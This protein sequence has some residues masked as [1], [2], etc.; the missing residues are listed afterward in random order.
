MTEIISVREKTTSDISMVLLSNEDVIDLKDVDHVELEMIDKSRKAYHYS[1]NDSPAYLDIADDPT[2]GVVTFTP[3]GE[4]V[5]LYQR[6]P[7]RLY[8][9]VYET[10]TKH[11]SV[12]ENGY[13][14]IQ[15]TKEY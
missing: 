1:S 7:Y 4:T 13:A 12:P 15:I 11:Y 5:F 10:S 2:T 9:K 14:E 8:I 3:S 6:S